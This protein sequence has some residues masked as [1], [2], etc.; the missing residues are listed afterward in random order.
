MALW[1]NGFMVLFGTTKPLNHKAIKQRFAIHLKL[2]NMKA[3]YLSIFMFCFLNLSEGIAI[4]T[5]SK[6][7]T[8]QIQETEISIESKEKSSRWQR[9]KNKVS[10]KKTLLSK[11]FQ[12]IKRKALNKV[13]VA[14]GLILGVSF[15]GGG[16]LFL[17]SLFVFSGLITSVYTAAII[18]GIIAAVG[19]YIL[20]DYLYRQI[21]KE[22]SP[23]WFKLTSGFFVA[24][25]LLVVFAYLASE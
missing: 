7:T 2:K 24:M 1:F 23:L 6:T 8:H 4:N 13:G 5:A 12:K 18:S 14:I 11:W 20:S 9:F 22:K 16:L 21:V 3:F 17:G 15:F 10:Q 25:P 19:G